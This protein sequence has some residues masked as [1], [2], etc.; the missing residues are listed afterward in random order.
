MSSDH[1][2]LTTTCLED[3]LLVFLHQDLLRAEGEAWTSLFTPKHSLKLQGVE[4]PWDTPQIEGCELVDT[5]SSCLLQRGK[6]CKTSPSFPG[7]S[8]DIDSPVPA[9][10]SRKFSSLRLPAP[11]SFLGI[12]SQISCPTWG[13]A[14]RG[15]Q[16]QTPGKRC[17]ICFKQ[18][19]RGLKLLLPAFEVRACYFYFKAISLIP[20]Y[21]EYGIKPI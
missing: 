9:E 17:L 7:G 16:R 8:S 10:W 1:V 11:L 19:L 13:F 5:G 14:L 18:S 15:I 21:L 20:Q 12:I 3:A 4:C 2:T 6:F